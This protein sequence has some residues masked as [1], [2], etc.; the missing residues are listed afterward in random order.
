MTFTLLSRRQLSW[1]QWVFL[2]ILG[3]NILFLLLGLRVVP[4]TL[5]SPAAWG[6][7][8]ADIGI[9]VVLGM[10]ALVGPLAFHHYSRS[11]G[12]TLALGVI[13]AAAYLSV[14]GFETG[15]VQ[16]SFDTGPLTIYALFIATS[17]VA[18]VIATLRTQRLR[19]GIVAGFWALMIGTA[20]WTVGVLIMNY[21]L[22][23]SSRWY[24]F[25][26]GDGALDDF[27]QSGSS[28]LSAFLLEDLRGA[29]FWHPI[30]SAVIGIVG[31]FVGYG[32]GRT[33]IQAQ[34]LFQA[35]GSSAKSSSI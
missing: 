6:E 9:Q 30:L 32:I 12:I 28:D 1:P 4:S 22:W 26:V 18:G 21:A 8:L 23:G 24:H 10:L 31:G 7:L 29:V 25:W 14:L 2:L 13:F 16:L 3:A 17:L 20:L 27:R 34:R 35:K 11:M 15:G 5:S 19:V 33:L